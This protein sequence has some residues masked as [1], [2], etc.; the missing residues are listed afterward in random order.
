MAG[1]WQGSYTI[2]HTLRRLYPWTLY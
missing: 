1:V 2:L